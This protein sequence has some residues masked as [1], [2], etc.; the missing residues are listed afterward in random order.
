MDIVPEYVGAGKS[1]GLGGW[2]GGSLRVKLKMT[3]AEDLRRCFRFS[4][5]AYYWLCW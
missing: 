4:E 1:D 5:V 2:G 3:M